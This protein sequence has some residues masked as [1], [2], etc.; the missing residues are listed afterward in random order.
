MGDGSGV[1]EKRCQEPIR[2][3]QILGATSVEG[4]DRNTNDDNFAYDDNGSRVG[5]Q[6]SFGASQTYAS[7][8][9]N[10]QLL[11]DGVYAYT[12]D[13]EGNRLTKTLLVTGSPTGERTNYTWDH[14]NRLIQVNLLDVPAGTLLR[15][16]KYAYDQ[17]NLRI[18]RVEDTDGDTTFENG[19]RASFLWDGMTMLAER[20]N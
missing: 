5:S 1:G 19:T 12:Y 9:A 15:S 20:G 11:N 14:R 8:G 10:N 6:D 3:F 18:E 17:N 16:V 2:L 7:A 13:E 4:A